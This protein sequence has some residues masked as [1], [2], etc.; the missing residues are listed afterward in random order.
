MTFIQILFA[1]ALTSFAFSPP[2]QHSPNTARIKRYFPHINKLLWMQI[3]PTRNEEVSQEY[4]RQQLSF[5]LQKRRELNADSAAQEQVGKVI[6]G[7]KGN[8]I[9]DFVSGSPNKAYILEEAPDVFDY[10]EL[11]KY[12]FDYLVEPIMAAGGRRAMYT[13]MNM[14]EPP[15]PHRLKPKQVPKL[16]IDRTGET[17]TARYSGLKMTQT[18]DDE[19]MG[20]RLAEI[21]QMKKEGGVRSLR[22]KL[23]EEEFDIPFSDGTFSF[24]F[25]TKNNL[26][27]HDSLFV[28]KLPGYRHS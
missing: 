4:L 2:F 15:T 9:L 17:D 21:Q 6:G 1:N 22:R 19:E 8:A 12:G 10:D 23:V 27:Y 25:V 5:Y 14:E 20:Q 28:D 13:L 26:L 16:I 7:T 24:H 11:V 18:L 3:N